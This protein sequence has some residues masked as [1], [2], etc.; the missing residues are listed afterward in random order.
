MDIIKEYYKDQIELRGPGNW[1]AKPLETDTHCI[2]RP[3]DNAPLT[4]KTLA[5]LFN[6]IAKDFPTASAADINID[7]DNNRVEVRADAPKG[8]K[9]LPNVTTAA[10][11]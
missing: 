2:L 3:A 6:V 7:N 5:A 1:N 4:S 9:R 10:R 8:Y 11:G